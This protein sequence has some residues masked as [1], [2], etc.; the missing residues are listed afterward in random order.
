M[1]PLLRVEVSP[2]GEVVD[3]VTRAVA[4]H[5]ITD[6][7]IVSIVG[8]VDHCCISTMPENDARS[9]V[10]TEYKVPCEL[11]GTGEVRNG[12]P[13]IHCVLG[14]EGDQARF[15]HLHW[16]RVETFFVHLYVMPLT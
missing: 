12:K 5:D 7:A 3:A 2:G 10:L 14:L 1:A 4:Q 11:S 9:D 16:A 6:A 15:G 8:A 13:H